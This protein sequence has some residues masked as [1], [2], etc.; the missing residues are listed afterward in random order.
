MLREWLRRYLV[1]FASTKS[2][3]SSTTVVGVMKS[4]GLP[5]RIHEEAGRFS[6]IPANEDSRRVLRAW[7]LLWSGGVRRMSAT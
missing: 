6:C 1:D 2:W 5:A 3:L 4:A 7:Y